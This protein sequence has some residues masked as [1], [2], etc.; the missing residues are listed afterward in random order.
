MKFTVIIT[1]DKQGNVFAA[2]P[3]LP[4]CHVQAATRDEV[5]RKIRMSILDIIHRSEI[6][7]LDVP[8]GDRPEKLKQQTPWDLFG[9]YPNAPEWSVFF[10][11]VEQNREREQN[12]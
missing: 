2:T 9:A 12:G 6:I 11:Q 3:G 5:I 10:D 7:Q 8:I 4:D 1:E